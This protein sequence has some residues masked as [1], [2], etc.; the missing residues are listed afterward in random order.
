MQR[1]TLGTHKICQHDIED[2]RRRTKRRRPF[3]ILRSSAHGLLTRPEHGQQRSLKSRIQKRKKNTAYQGEIEPECRTLIHQ[4]LLFSPERPAHHT[5]TSHAKQI[6]HRIE[7][8][9]NRCCQR[10]CCILHRV[11]YHADK[12]RICQI[13]NYHDE[14][15]DNRRY[16]RRHYRPGYRRPFK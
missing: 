1:R 12:I 3:E 2:C 15:T 6:I 7:S 5:R 11:I 8:K 10:N 9:K 16:G 13:I 4:F 14:R